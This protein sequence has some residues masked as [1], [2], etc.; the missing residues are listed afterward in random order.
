[1][2]LKRSVIRFSKTKK[3]RSQCSIAKEWDMIP[4]EEKKNDK[5]KIK[6]RFA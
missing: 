6:T 1:M 5:M 2:T 3:H 4:E